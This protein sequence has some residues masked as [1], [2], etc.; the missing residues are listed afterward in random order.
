MRVGLPGVTVTSG[1]THAVTGTDGRALLPA[2]PFGWAAHVTVDIDTLPLSATLDRNER[3]VQPAPDALVT[4]A[5]FTTD[6][7]R[8]NLRQL[9]PTYRS[10]RTHSSASSTSP[11][12]TAA[13]SS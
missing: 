2:P 11:C 7:H 4:V 3:T 1:T 9:P 13:T 6:L 8:S 5:D 10:A 12:P